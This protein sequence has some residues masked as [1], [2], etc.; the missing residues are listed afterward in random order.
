MDERWNSIDLN[1]CPRAFLEAIGFGGLAR[2]AL[3]VR[4]GQEAGAETWVG[5][6]LNDAVK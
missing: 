5:G 3:G 2:A 1:A 6:R 4:E